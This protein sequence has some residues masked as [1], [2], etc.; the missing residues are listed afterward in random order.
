MRQRRDWT[1]WILMFVLFAGAMGLIFYILLLRA[2]SL[3][4]ME[5]RRQEPEPSARVEQVA[6]KHAPTVSLSS[7][8]GLAAEPYYLVIDAEASFG[9]ARS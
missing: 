9:V 3:S 1:G 2:Q 7:A 8:P 4:D 6:A 5:Q